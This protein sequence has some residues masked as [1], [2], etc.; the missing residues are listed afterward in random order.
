MLD[1]S[2]S[3]WEARY[4]NDEINRGELGDRSLRK[5]YGIGTK[6][7]YDAVGLALSGGGIRSATFC[8]ASSRSWLKA[9]HEGL[10]LPLDGVRSGYAGAFLTS[11]VGSAAASRRWATIRPDTAGLGTCVEMPNP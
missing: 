6:S 2:G 8:L 11:W 9:I 5:A 7:G 1:L 10:R 4:R 3:D